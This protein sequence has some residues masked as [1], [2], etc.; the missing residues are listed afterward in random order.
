[1]IESDRESRH[2]APP[3]PLAE[4]QKKLL[5]SYRPNT[6]SSASMASPLLLAALVPLCHFLSSSELLLLHTENINK[7][8][9]MT[10]T[11]T[12]DSKI[13]RAT[14]KN[15]WS[16]KISYKLLDFEER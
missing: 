14:H 5:V 11:F 10:S 8:H 13:E 2:Q 1:M 3:P 12:L 16:Y 4:L 15:K 6:A 7:G 9:S